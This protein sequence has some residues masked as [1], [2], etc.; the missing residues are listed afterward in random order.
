MVVIMLGVR[1]GPSGYHTIEQ[2]ANAHLS[3]RFSGRFG[4]REILNSFVNTNS[5][6]SCVANYLNSFVI[7]N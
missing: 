2:D 5:C 1:A 7:A 6:A 4:H 3:L